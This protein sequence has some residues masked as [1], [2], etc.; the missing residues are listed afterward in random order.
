MLAYEPLGDIEDAAPM[1]EGELDSSESE[2]EVVG[3]GP[4]EMGVS[5]TCDDDTLVGGGTYDV[6]GT[7]DGETLVPD[8]EEEP[9]CE[10]TRTGCKGAG[11]ADADRD[12]G[13]W[14]GEAEVDGSA[15]GD[16]GVVSGGGAGSGDGGAS[17]ETGDVG[18]GPGT[19][20]GDEL[21]DTAGG[22]V[23]ST[24]AGEGPDPDEGSLRGTVAV[25]V[26]DG[27]TGATDGS[28]TAGGEL[29]VVETSGL[30]TTSAGSDWFGGGTG[31]A[32]AGAGVG[33]GTG[34]T[35]DAGFCRLR[36]R[37][38]VV[39]TDESFHRASLGIALA[40]AKMAGQYHRDCRVDP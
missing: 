18:T 10:S 19:G 22:L 36:G 32:G 30:R 21:G 13:G 38:E 29:V 7:G 8:A 9:S 3:S 1:F 35:L 39:E 11:S 27:G 37:S 4:D 17:N 6:S 26:S 23:D 25:D 34:S 33:T 5:T 28:G 20:S 2:D 16:D 31:A 24:G 15:G 40:V 12:G 14:T